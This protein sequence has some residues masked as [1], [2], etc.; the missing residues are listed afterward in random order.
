MFGL[1]VVLVN[2]QI[3]LL[4]HSK[5]TCLYFCSHKYNTYIYI[6]ILKFFSLLYIFFL[7]L[8]EI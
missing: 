3:I 4:N 5:I 2:E 7:D 1:L 6:T 8:T